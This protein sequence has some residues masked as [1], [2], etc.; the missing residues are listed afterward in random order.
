MNKIE[1]ETEFEKIQNGGQQKQTPVLNIENNDDSIILSQTKTKGRPRKG[2]V[3][4]NNNSAANSRP[5]SKER[6]EAWT[7]DTCDTVFQSDQSKL[8]EC[9]YCKT[10][11]CIKCLNMPAACYKGFNEERTFHG[12]AITAFQKH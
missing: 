4:S 11:R 9:E 10:H 12:F 5:N 2:S 3:L 6:K 7:C 1:Q 8:L